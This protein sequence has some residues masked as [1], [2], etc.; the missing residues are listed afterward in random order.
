M[1][2][3]TLE[4]VQYCDKP[5]IYLKLMLWNEKLPSCALARSK[6]HGSPLADIFKYSVM[7]TRSSYYTR[8]QVRGILRKEF[9]L[10]FIHYPTFKPFSP[11]IRSTQKVF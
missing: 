3:D 10:S 5:Q 11:L 8:I 4:P 1:L 7:E 6:D 9:Q 2:V